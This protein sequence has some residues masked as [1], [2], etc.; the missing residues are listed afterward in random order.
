MAAATPGLT[1]ALVRMAYRCAYRLALAWWWLRRP[2]TL[3][4]LVALWRGD[5][6]LLVRTSYRGLF[7]LPGGFAGPDEPRAVAAARELREEVGMTLDPRCLA[8]AWQGTIAFEFRRDAVTIFDA[9]VD[10]APSP[11]VDNREIVWADWVPR[12]E[13]LRLPL[14]P[15]VRA[16]LETDRPR[17]RSGCGGVDEG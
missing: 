12:D 14:L 13:A 17:L 5:R 7:S 4:V 3:G 15:H 16:Y 10:P 9:C 2:R 1:D 6:V 8:P 11:V